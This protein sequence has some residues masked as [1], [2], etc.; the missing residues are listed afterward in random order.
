[1]DRVKLSELSDVVRAW[2]NEIRQGDG[3]VIEDD[4]GQG[5]YSV[6]PFHQATADERQ[7]ALQHLGRLQAQTRQGMDEQGVTEDDIDQLL[8]K[9]A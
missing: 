3:V 5:R 9:D 7:A 2:L 1:M 6:A 4:A 8:Q